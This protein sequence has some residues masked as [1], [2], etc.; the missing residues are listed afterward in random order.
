[1][2]NFLHG[3]SDVKAAVSLNKKGTNNIEYKRLESHAFVL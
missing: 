1:M 3:E 2:Y